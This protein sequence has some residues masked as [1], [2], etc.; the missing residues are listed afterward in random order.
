MSLS[1]PVSVYDS[2]K[3]AALAAGSEDK[4]LDILNDNLVYRGP[5]ADIRSEF[6]DYLESKT[7]FERLVV[8]TTTRK[9]KDAAGVES[10][11]EVPKYESEGTYIRR[12][13]AKAVAGELTSAGIPANEEQLEAHLQSLADKFVAA[14]DPFVV[15]AASPEPKAKKAKSPRKACLDIAGK[16]HASGAFDKFVKNCSKHKVAPGDYQTGDKDKDILTIAWAV[17]ATQ[18]AIEAAAANSWVQS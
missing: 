9:V 7:G 13:R 10:E 3:E 11:E 18:D 4:A 1:F 6:A 15:D 2:F 14:H 12:L 17:Q 8:E 5:A 16:I